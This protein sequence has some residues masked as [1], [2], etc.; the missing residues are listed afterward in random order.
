MRVSALTKKNEELSREVEKMKERLLTED[1]SVSYSEERNLLLTETDELLAE[2]DKMHEQE[3]ILQE[4]RSELIAQADK[5]R[6]FGELHCEVADLRAE[7]EMFRRSERELAEA[8]KSG[9]TAARQ[10]AQAGAAAAK[11]SDELESLRRQ[12]YTLAEE[13]KRLKVEHQK[14]AAMSSSQIREHEAKNAELRKE[15]E[16]L[17]SQADSQHELEQENQRLSVVTQELLHENRRLAAELAKANATSAAA[18]TPPAA[19]ANDDGGMGGCGGGGGSEGRLRSVMLSLTATPAELR[20]AIAATEALVEEARR[21]LRHKE[22]RERRAA[23]E[24]LKNAIEKADEE[25]LAEAIEFARRTGV[26][27]EEISQGEAKLLALRSL[28]EEQKAAKA[29]RELETKRKKRGFLL[30]KKDDDLGLRLFLE[31]LAEDTRWKEWRDYAGRTMWRCS[32]EL[33]A[34]RAQHVLAPL[35]GLRVPE[36]GK[37]RPWPSKSSGSFSSAAG[38]PGGGG[39]GTAGSSPA[40]TPGTSPTGARS[41]NAT[42]PSL[43][44]PDGWD[45]SCAIAE[46]AAAGAGGVH[47]AE[48]AERAAERGGEPAGPP[49]A[50]EDAEP[51]GLRPPPPPQPRLTEAELADYKAR[52]LKAV[53]RDDAEELEAVL[54]AVPV[55]TWASWSNKAGKDF[56]TLSQERGSSCAYSMLAK[57]LGMLKEM[58]RDPFEERESIWVFLNGDVQPRRATVLED[59]P[60]DYEDILVEYWDGDDP[61]VRVDR[62]MVRKMFS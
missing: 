42:Q 22:L 35:I 17:Q 21:E 34:V 46:G 40:A 38:S 18:S 11:L 33:H 4:Q 61:P 1:E 9:E 53:A 45:A 62:C 5:V 15:K 37:P 31:E 19:P 29:A 25:P 50:P 60:E 52:G 24:Q 13:V 23:Y 56:L 2:T 39:G 36:D 44:F 27:V 49:A 7:C 57:A 51:E 6:T 20:N 3:L 26:E 59:T 48:E 43:G 28:T 32:Q 58:K 55:S 54:T 47:S 16:M 12:N 10:R 14:K 8:Q 30:V 41:I